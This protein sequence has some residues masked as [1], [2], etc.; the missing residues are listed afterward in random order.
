[1]S[2]PSLRIR[3]RLL[4]V[5]IMAAVTAMAL[6]GCEP[7]ALAPADSSDPTTSPTVTVEPTETTE[8][9]QPDDTETPAETDTPEVTTP[10]VAG[11]LPCTDVFTADQ[12]YA[13]NPNFAPSSDQGELPGAIADIADAGGTVCAYQHVTG[14]DRLVVGV[15]EGPGDFDAPPFETVGEI[16]VASAQANGAVIAAASI[17][18]VE[19]RDAQQVL[20][21]VAANVN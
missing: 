8:P 11:D 16:G 1:M 18:F 5:T 2:S 12:L 21:E 10:P 17:Y 14:S 6:T 19:A 7:G 20:D 15:L 3:P 4:P 9:G 13:F